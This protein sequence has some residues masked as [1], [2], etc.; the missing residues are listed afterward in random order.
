MGEVF[1]GFFGFAGGDAIGGLQLHQDS[2][3]VLGEGVVDFAG[4]EGA[5]LDQG[6]LLGC[7]RESSKLNR[8]G[9]LLGKCL[10]KF[11]FFGGKFAAL[12]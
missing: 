5:F 4:G 6:E 8:E 10:G 11:Q 9:G 12:G 2:A 3:K 7:F 1:L